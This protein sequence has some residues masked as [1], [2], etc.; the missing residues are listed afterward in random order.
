MT[1]LVLGLLRPYRGWLAIVFA[2]MLLEIAASLAAPWPLKLV[3]DDALGK[4][5]L[6]DW[7]AWAHD[8]G[9]GRHT[10]GVAMFA[11]AATLVIAI[12]SA[13]AT[14]IDIT[15]PPASDNGLR[16]ICGSGFTNTCIDCRSAFTIPPRRAP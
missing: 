11:G 3:L 16:T 14:Y 12:I 13:L 15:T 2:A 1:R 8:Y 5:R 4:H 9:F 10:L 7:L 6:P